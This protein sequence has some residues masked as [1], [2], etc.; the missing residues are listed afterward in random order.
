[1]A[2]T[3][4]NLLTDVNSWPDWHPGVTHAHLDGPFA[5]GA[6]FQWKANGVK[7]VSTVQE[8]EPYRHIGWTGKAFGTEAVHTWTLIAKEN[9]VLLK[10]EESFDG[11]LV[12]LFTG[13]MQKSLEKA[14]DVWLVSLKAKAEQLSGT[15]N[16]TR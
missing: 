2:E 6:I 8:T 11:W 5:A 7:I 3:V 16:R 4:W 12:K 13:M 9:G 1:M 14:L 15:S 10:T